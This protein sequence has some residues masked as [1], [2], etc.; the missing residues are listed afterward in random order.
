[1]ANCFEAIEGMIGE[2]WIKASLDRK[3]PLIR[4]ENTDESVSMTN[5]DDLKFLIGAS[6]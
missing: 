3:K 2:G 1:M 6:S 4:V 5:E